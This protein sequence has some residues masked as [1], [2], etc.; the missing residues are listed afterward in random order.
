MLENV[1]KVQ[2][3]FWG[4]SYMYI[5]LAYIPLYIVFSFFFSFIL[6][7][8]ICFKQDLTLSIIIIS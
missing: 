1:F 4:F 7:V 8:L 2:I 5:Y 6:S 3:F